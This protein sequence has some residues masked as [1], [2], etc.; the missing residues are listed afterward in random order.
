MLHRVGPRAE[1][2]ELTESETE[3]VGDGRNGDL[4]QLRGTTST[5]GP[6]RRA[7]QAASTM[8]GQ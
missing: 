7:P 4:Q 8:H 5:E 3:R 2:A 1:L 6:R